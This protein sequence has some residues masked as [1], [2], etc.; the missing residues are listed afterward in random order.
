MSSWIL[1]LLGA[2]WIVGLA[3]ALYFAGWGAA[4]LDPGARGAPWSFR[5]LLIPAASAL[6][7][8]LMVR[9]LRAEAPAP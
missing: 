2:Y 8:A 9:L 3:F 1:N 6:W 5:L 4:K 7:P